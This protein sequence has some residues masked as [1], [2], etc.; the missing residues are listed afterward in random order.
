MQGEPGPQSVEED[1]G[2]LRAG[3]VQGE[4]GAGESAGVGRSDE[5]VQGE[6]VDG[7]DDGG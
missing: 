1:R 7:V 5:R 4:A 2:T 6:R 3:S